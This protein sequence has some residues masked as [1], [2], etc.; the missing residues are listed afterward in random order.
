M[1]AASEATPSSVWHCGRVSP[2]SS[3]Q[4]PHLPNGVGEGEGG[5]EPE[6]QAPW[7]GCWGKSR[8]QTTPNLSGW[9]HPLSLRLDLSLG[10]GRARAITGVEVGQRFT[11]SSLDLK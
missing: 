3:T 5:T 8:S 9:Q 2:P 4:L 6:R 1:G 11:G 7:A 10:A